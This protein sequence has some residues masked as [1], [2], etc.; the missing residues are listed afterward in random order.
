MV[1]TLIVARSWYLLKVE[2]QE[3][4]CFKS[5]MDDEILHSS[6]N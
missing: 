2:G 5:G 1:K 4:V 6:P 3:H